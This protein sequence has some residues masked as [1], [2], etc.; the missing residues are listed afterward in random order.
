MISVSLDPLCHRLLCLQGPPRLPWDIHLGAHG[1][2]RSSCSQPLSP[3]LCLPSFACL[4]CSGS[5]GLHLIYLSGQDRAWPWRGLRKGS[6]VGQKWLFW[7]PWEQVFRNLCCLGCRGWTGEAWVGSRPGRCI[8]VTQGWLLLSLRL[9]SWM[10]VLG[11]KVIPAGL[12]FSGILG[13]VFT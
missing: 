12:R 4:L 7:H 6:L 13:S 11:G 9:P 2:E 5:W 1:P 8:R 10:V 3:G